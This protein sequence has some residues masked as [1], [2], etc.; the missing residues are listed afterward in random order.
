MTTFTVHTADPRQTFETERVGHL[1]DG[2][3]EFIS[4]GT[5]YRMSASFW[6]MITKVEGS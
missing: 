2:G 5:N 6:T 1:A 4:Q 3:I